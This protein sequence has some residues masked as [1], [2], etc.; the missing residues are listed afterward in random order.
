MTRKPFTQI[1]GLLYTL[2]HPDC[3]NDPERGIQYAAKYFDIHEN[4]H[5]AKV[6]TK[7]IKPEDRTSWFKTLS[8]ENPRWLDWFV[9]IRKAFNHGADREKAAEQ[10]LLLC[11]AEDPS[12]DEFKHW[13]YAAEQTN[14]ERP[15]IDHTAIHFNQWL[16]TRV[17]DGYDKKTDK[18]IVTDKKTDERREL[19]ADL[20]H[21][22]GQLKLSPGNTFIEGEIKRVE[23]LIDAF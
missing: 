11:R 1:A 8:A 16:K 3:E 17:F 12:N 19:M 15:F 10:F 4:M 23:A 18:E 21:F 7:K 20:N 5:K 14:K 2:F 9:A 6:V 13:R 22:K